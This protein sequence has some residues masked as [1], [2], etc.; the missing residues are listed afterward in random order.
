M[1]MCD[2]MVVCPEM[3]IIGKSIMKNIIARIVKILS[4]VFLTFGVIFA[5]TFATTPNSSV[6]ADEPDEITQPGNNEPSY[7]LETDNDANPDS[8][9]YGLETN[10]ETNPNDPSYGL[11]DD[12]NDNDNGPS[13][14]LEPGDEDSDSGPSYGLETDDTNPEGSDDETTPNTCEDQVGALAW[15]VCPTTGVIAKFIDA[16]YNVV[17][18]LSIVPPLS[19]EANSPIYLVWQYARNITNIVF[20]IF[21][22]IVIYS[23]ITG[24]G[25]NN[26]GVKRILPRLIIAIILVNLSFIICSLAV[27]LSNI[28]GSNLREFFTGIQ[29]SVI[30][31]G[32]ASEIANV[33]VGEIVSSII[34]GTGIAG[35]AIGAT[36]GFASLFWMLV[37][38]LIGAVVA[39]VSGLLTIAARQ[40]LVALLI[41]ISPLAFVAY[42]LPNTEKWFTKWKNLLFQMLIFYPMFSFL[43]GASQLAGWALITS[44]KDGFGLIL[45][46]AVQIFPLVFSWSLM[47]MSGTILGAVNTGLRKLAAP[48]ERGLAGWSLSHKELNRQRYLANS[49]M[50]GAKL[51]RYLDYRRELREL[52]TKNSLEIRHG[53]AHERALITASSSTGVDKDGNDTWSKRANRYT[54]NAKRAALYETRVGVANA[55]YRNTLSAYGRHFSGS[56]ASRLSDA[57]GE[58]YLE[59]MKQQFLAANEAQADQDYLLDKYLTASINSERNP[60]QFNRLV[61][62][63][64]GSLGHTGESSIMGQ[65]IVGNANIERRRRGEA[66]IIMTKFGVDKAAARGMFLDINRIGDNGREIDENGEEIEDEMWN[67]KPGKQ[68]TPWQHY[69]G[70]HKTTGVEITKEEYDALDPAEREAH[71]RKVRYFDIRNDKKQL[72]QRVY[73]DDAGYMKEL[74]V[75][76]INIADPIND[77]YAW[78]IG[79]GDKPG[80]QTGI[81]R[82][83]H[84]TISAAMLGANYKEKDAAYTSML[85]AHLDGGGIA[86]PG[87]LNIAKW[88]S[89]NA[90]A[91]PNMFPINDVWAIKRYMNQL[92]TLNFAPEDIFNP[93]GTYQVDSNYLKDFAFWFPQADID[94]YTNVNQE[95]LKGV[96]PVFDEQGNFKKWESISFNESTLEQKQDYIKHVI[97]TRGAKKLVGV[98]NR[99]LSPNVMDNQKP[100]TLEALIA[101]ADVLETLG[102]RNIDPNV[103]YD[104]KLD[105]TV[106]IYASND[107]GIT[108]RLV[109]AAKRRLTDY[110]AGIATPPSDENAIDIDWGDDDEDDNPPPSTPHGPRPPQPPRP[111]RGSGGNPSAKISQLRESIR[112]LAEQLERLESDQEA[113]AQLDDINTILD[114]L[115]SQATASKNMTDFAKRFNGFASETSTLQDPILAPQ[116]QE[117]IRQYSQPPRPTSTD[118]AGGSIDE[119]VNAAQHNRNAIN[120][121]ANEISQLL[122]GTSLFDLPDDNPFLP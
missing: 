8:P 74:L 98:L 81:L 102:Q 43:F 107:P 9:S 111:P 61:R 27:D 87:E 31:N 119:I 11:D 103:P 91:K 18:G 15:I 24:V 100:D 21:L 4:I 90:S 114:V 93:D 106:D 108:K 14:G 58:A 44:A 26:Y 83:Y 104:Q 54:E 64:A 29:E 48:A 66:S 63:A 116:I 57:H 110:R 94:N 84:S 51:R 122:G 39:V 56:A 6:Y 95:F 115:K 75:N 33:P 38:V 70:V 99:N 85:A 5:T 19:M 105:P 47:K 67:L 49:T 1:L 20:V 86:T 55:A 113:Q 16:I 97:F 92:N 77:R 79:I 32:E 23:Q 7:G 53:K 60:Y 22:L 10:D 118:G 59:S 73:E 52:D 13:Y 65:V 89:F 112:V 80:E 96:R 28:I 78:S 46:I 36:G 68:H 17:D 3:G 71:Y 30:A 76:N 109:E 42:L 2:I 35:I 40:A 45:G 12:N 117:I 120:A 69:I 62:G 50:P 37:P 88:Q 72:V 41:M 121:A 25:L 82:R 101:L 34:A